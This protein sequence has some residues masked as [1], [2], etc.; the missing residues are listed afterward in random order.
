MMLVTVPYTPT[1][2]SFR[3]IPATQDAPYVDCV[4]W[5]DKKVLE[6][7]SIIK[8]NEYAMFP[9]VDENGDI[10][11]RKVAITQENGQKIE[12]KQERR[13]AEIF[14]KFYIIEKD[15]EP[16]QNSSNLS[17][18][19]PLLIRNVTIVPDCQR[20]TDASQ[21]HFYTIQQYP[22]IAIQI[23]TEILANHFPCREKRPTKPDKGVNPRLQSP[24]PHLITNIESLSTR[25][26]IFS[27]HMIFTAHAPNIRISKVGNNLLNP[28]RIQDRGYIR[29]NKDFP[30]G[31]LDSLLLGVFLPPTFRDSE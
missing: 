18:K 19:L 12:H 30:F 3:L 13:M 31:F 14:Q 2:N 27:D 1:E 10:E 6:V 15:R 16:P 7:N 22:K 23:L 29:K 26:P 5:K 17:F 11:R 9:K 28:P 24:K 25:F 20:V 21:A 4:Y 8:K